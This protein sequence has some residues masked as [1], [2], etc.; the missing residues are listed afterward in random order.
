MA[1]LVDR[2]GM[3]R[4]RSGSLSPDIRVVSAIG[5]PPDE[6]IVEEHAADEREIVE[7]SSAEEWVVHR[8]LHARLDATSKALEDR[9]HRRRHR[10]KMNGDVLGL[11]Q[12]LARRDEHSR[13]AVSPLLDVR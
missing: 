13:R 1:L 6:A 8:V 10:A 5:R 2:R 7:V 11:G 9:S 12:H 4:H 3:G